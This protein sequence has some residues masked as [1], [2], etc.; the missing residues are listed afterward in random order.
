[1]DRINAT[2]G[3]LDELAKNVKKREKNTSERV[4]ELLRQIQQLEGEKDI[5]AGSS[6]RLEEQL[7]AKER[8][9]TERS[10]RDQKTINELE[11]QLQKKDKD[12]RSREII[13]LDEEK[14]LR[15]EL[16]RK[17]QELEK[18][19]LL[20]EETLNELEQSRGPELRQ[21]MGFA[22][23]EV[24]DVH[25]IAKFEHEEGEREGRAKESEMEKQLE[26]ARAENSELQ[27]SL[28]SMSYKLAQLFNSAYEY[29]GAKLL[30]YL[31]TSIG[32]TEF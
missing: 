8:E 23:M 3:K 19:R 6:R 13:E 9:N 26:R 14:K 31:Q 21:S 20:Y 27:G 17:S 18:Y 4:P 12:F 11:K 7:A 29:G 24:D 32:L 10:K 25:E 5:L 2:I 16:A 30:D 15:D 22:K 28:A 1:M